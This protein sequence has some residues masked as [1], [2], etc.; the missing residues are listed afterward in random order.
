MIL[1]A[2]YRTDEQ[3]LKRLCSNSHSAIRWCRWNR[4]EKDRVG[5]KLSDEQIKLGIEFVQDD[6]R[7]LYQK[8]LEA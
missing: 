7:H 6:K 2:Q 4:I 1:Q 3:M 5:D 8:W